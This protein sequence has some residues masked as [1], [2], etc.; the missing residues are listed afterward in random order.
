LF[1]PHLF[2]IILAAAAFMMATDTAAVEAIAPWQVG[3]KWQAGLMRATPLLCVFG[4][5]ILSRLSPR[6]NQSRFALLRGVGRIPVLGRYAA[7]AIAA[8][9][10]TLLLSLVLFTSVQSL[11]LS[12]DIPPESWLRIEQAVGGGVTCTT[13]CHGTRVLFLEEKRTAIKRAL[14]NEGIATEG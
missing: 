3:L 9:A 10:V 2:G 8:Q 6:G 13:D 4:C 12:R 14:H 7:F 5:V 11:K 1:S